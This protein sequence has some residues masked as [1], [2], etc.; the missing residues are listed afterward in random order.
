MQLVPRALR[1][2]GVADANVRCNTP[3]Y[4]AVPIPPIA[5]EKIR[6]SISNPVRWASSN[7]LGGFQYAG[8]KIGSVR[9]KSMVARL[10]RHI[11]ARSTGF[12]R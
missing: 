1:S 2:A 8:T 10:T 6:L 4:S 9:P 5:N 3:S 11:T 7:R 12:V